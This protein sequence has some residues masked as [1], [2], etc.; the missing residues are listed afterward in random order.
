MHDFKGSWDGYLLMIKFSHNNSYNATTQ[1]ILLSLYY[2]RCRSFIGWFKIGK[3][4]LI[5]QELIFEG[6]KV[7]RL[8][9]EKLRTSQSQKKVIIRYEETGAQI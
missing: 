8:I 2:K 5:G 7:V 3:V 1:I 9:W 6:M 4:D